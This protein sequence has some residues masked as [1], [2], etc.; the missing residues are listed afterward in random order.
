V[1][2]FLNHQRVITIDS[3]SVPYPLFVLSGVILWTAF[4]GSLMSMLGVI[5]AARAFLGKVNFPHESLIYSA[6]MKSLLDALLAALMVIPALFLFAGNFRSTIVL[7][8]VAL[9]G[10]IV[11]GT[12]IGILILPVAA[13]YNDVSRAIQ[14][15]LRFAFFLA[16]VVFALPASGIARKIMLLNPATP[17][18]ATGR[19]W[20]TGSGEAMTVGFILVLAVSL[21]VLSFGMIVFKV[22]LPHLIERVAS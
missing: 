16:P 1:W 20:L 2:V 4:N 13:L 11:A 8:P 5:G 10:S 19:D 18:I 15:V 6:V 12:A 21:L 22:V 17:I 3:G 9:L 14:L 7:F